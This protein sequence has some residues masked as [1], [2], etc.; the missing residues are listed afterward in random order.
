MKRLTHLKK[1]FNE[2]AIEK[3]RNWKSIQC[4][5]TDPTATAEAELHIFQEEDKGS[6]LDALSDTERHHDFT[7]RG[8][9]LETRRVFDFNTEQEDNHNHTD[10]HQLP[11]T[12]PRHANAVSEVGL[13]KSNNPPLQEHLIPSYQSSSHSPTT[14]LEQCTLSFPISQSFY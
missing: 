10:F 9:F 6:L 8:Q 2:S 14:S 12:Q 3:E 5:C 1:R 13:P 7:S 4:F 11:E